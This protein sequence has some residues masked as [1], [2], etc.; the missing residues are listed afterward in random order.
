EAARLGQRTKVERVMAS[1]ENILDALF[2]RT[3]QSLSAAA[4]RTFLTLCSWQS[5]VPRLAVEA[6][7]RRPSNEQMDV[8]KA[9][10][11]LEQSSLI[12]LVGSGSEAERFV[13]VPLAA[14]LFGRRKLIASPMKAAIAADVTLLQG[15]GPAKDADAGRGLQPGLDRM[16]RAVA[17]KAQ[18]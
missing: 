6:T 16:V 18:D 17:A 10:D 1:K 9:L 12:E 11:V 14:S 3:F 15:F 8:G 5:M 2:E 4:Q 13:R 7:L